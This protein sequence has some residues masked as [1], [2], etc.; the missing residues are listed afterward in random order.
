M[1]GY[2]RAHPAASD[3][4][5]GIREWWLSGLEPPPTD[6]QILEAL[7]WLLDRGRVR[8]IVNPDG[9]I[10]WAAGPWTGE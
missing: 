2:L 4:I 10:R 7:E 1:L 3:S 6:A 8:R 9:T 5:R